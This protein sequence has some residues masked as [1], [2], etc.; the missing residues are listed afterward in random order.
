MWNDIDIYD[1]YRDFTNDPNTYPSSELQAFIASL[2]AN[3]QHYVP[4]VDSNVYHPNPDNA[5]DAYAPFA[6]GAALGT[7]IRDPTTGGQ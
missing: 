1:L 5:S 7:F 2:H 3:G 4:I 6:R